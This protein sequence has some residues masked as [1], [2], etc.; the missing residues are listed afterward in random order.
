MVDKWVSKY[1]VLKAFLAKNYSTS[2]EGLNVDSCGF[3]YSYQNIISVN[4]N[5]EVNFI[6]VLPA[7]SLSPHSALVRN[8]LVSM[9]QNLG[10]EVLSCDPPV[11]ARLAAQYK[12]GH[13]RKRNDILSELV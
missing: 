7:S 6:M 10:Y 9:A 3:L 13:I 5:L 8:T 11:F 2:S 12:F 1:S 4:M